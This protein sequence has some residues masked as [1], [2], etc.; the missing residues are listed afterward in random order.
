MDVETQAHRLF[1]PEN[2][3]RRAAVSMHANCLIKLERYEEATPK[4]KYLCESSG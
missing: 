2:E 1:G 4:W 3:N